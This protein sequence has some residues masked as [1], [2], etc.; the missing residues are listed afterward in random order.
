MDINGLGALPRI[1]TVVPIAK[2][3]T[4]DTVSDGARNMDLSKL[5]VV[6]RETSDCVIITDTNFIVEWSNPA[7]TRIS[8]YSAE[9]L[10]GRNLLEVAHAF[11]LAPEMAAKMISAL[12]GGQPFSSRAW[13]LRKSG[14]RL[15]ADFEVFPY[16]NAQGELA[17]FIGITRDIT[18]QTLAEQALRESE[19]QLRDAQTLAGFG[20][21][22]YIVDT[23]ELRWSEQIFRA[24]GRP[25]AKGP[26]TFD[27]FMAYLHP[28]DR[29]EL[30]AC[31]RRAMHEDKPYEVHYQITRD[32]GVIAHMH[33]RGNPRHDATGR[34]VELHGTIQDV[35][36]R[37]RAEKERLDLHVQLASAQRLESLGLLA[38]GFAHDFNNLLMGLLMN[39][40]VLAREITPKPAIVEAVNNIQD[41][42][43]RMAELT[44][45]LLAYA[46]RGRF[47]AERIDPNEAVAQ[48]L[49]SLRGQLSKDTRLELDMQEKQSR[50]EIDPVQ[51]RH[52]VGNL[53][54][55]AV[56][57]LENR[58][59][60]ITIRTRSEKTDSG[61]AFWVFEIT[62]SGVGMTEEVQR[63]AFEPF[64]TT[65]KMGRGLGLSTVHGLVQRSRGDIALRSTVGGGTTFTIRLP[66]VAE[67]TSKCDIHFSRPRELEPL[68]ILLADDEATV[69]RSLRRML[70]LHRTNVTEAADGAAALEALNDKDEPF[71]VALLDIL[72]PRMTGYDVLAEMRKRRLPTKIILMSG[73]DNIDDLAGVKAPV[74][75]AD[76]TLQKP[77]TWEQ[78]KQVLQHVLELTP[79]P[80]TKQ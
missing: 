37:V 24:F 16:R 12:A 10:R 50:V 49:E 11:T 9:E 74:D 58:A 21:W 33:A 60:T 34:I 2:L 3:N 66:W 64:F 47:V 8:G 68:R 45:Q 43:A 5:A 75:N 53:F 79:A 19:E 48:E 52:M 23:Q 77:F 38:G 20:S 70:E 71:D 44:N 56:D 4:R 76:A 17:A 26:P 69:R 25:I 78:L 15:H 80:I 40:S 42:V 63:R 54:M 55:N 59:G 57:A 14:D 27:E 39:A 41:A 22:R 7:S 6:A 18:G 31:I 67:V 1:R 65:K 73:F 30:S 29:D 62:D 51:L 36:T 32:D 28:N 72:M 46:G 13:T 61:R 35:T